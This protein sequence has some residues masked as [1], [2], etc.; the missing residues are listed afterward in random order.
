MNRLH[1]ADSRIS[2]LSLCALFGHSKQAYYKA[3]SYHCHERLKSS[4]IL[5]IV[6]EIRRDMHHLGGRKLHQIVVDRIPED[7]F[8]GRDA[9]FDLLRDNDYLLRSRKFH[10]VTTN[11]YHHFHIYENLIQDFSP[12]APHQLYVSDITYV[13]GPDGCFY[14]LSLIT[15]AY[16]HKIVGWYLSETLE[17][18]GPIEALKMALSK[19]PDDAKLI[20][21][22][23]R[24]VQY[25]SGPYINLLK[26]A[27]NAEIRISMTQ[28][29]DPRENAI[30]ER[31]NGILKTEWIND[32]SFQSLEDARVRIKKVINLY[33]NERPHSSIQMMTPEQASHMQ[34]PLERKWKS[35]Y[36]K[37]ENKECNDGKY[38]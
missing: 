1:Q 33:N 30:A 22:S 9:F 19:L 3:W 28:N 34:G 18:K 12:T 25:C 27:A 16:S 5:K 23:D 6:E 8:I 32:M 14:Y 26:N 17:M 15:D 11:S 20:H 31:V 37:R 24:G 38:L 7:L 21:H 36:K 2:V 35:Y 10:P 4:V 29:G 13:D